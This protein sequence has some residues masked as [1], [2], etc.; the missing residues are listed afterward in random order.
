MRYVK[1]KKEWLLRGWTDEP[2]TLLNWTN[3]DCRKLSEQL[4][5]TASDC[6]GQTDF[7]NIADFF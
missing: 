2:W 7:D 1:L 6:D 4:F 3:G 5:L